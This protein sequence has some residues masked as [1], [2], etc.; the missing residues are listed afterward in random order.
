[1]VYNIL[2][3]LERAAARCPEKIALAD[4]QTSLTYGELRARAAQIGTALIRRC[5]GVRRPVFV[6]IDRNVESVLLFLGAVYSGNFYVPVD[7]A[8]PPAR[9]ESMYETVQPMAVLTAEET[10]LPFA[11]TSPILSL[12]EL[13]AEAEDL[14]ALDAVRAG[15]R[16]TDPLYCIFTSG[17]TGVPK[18]VVVGHRSVVDMAEGFTEVFGFGE[19]AVF[20]NQAPF[21]FDVSVKDIYIALKNAAT[22][23]ILE[24]KLFSFPKL[25]LERLGERR[26]NT[27]IWAASALKVV[28]ALRGLAKGGPEHLGTVCFS[29]EVLPCKALADWRAAL[30]E[31]RFI[32][33]YGPTEITCN[34]TYHVA[35]PG[36]GE[37]EPLPIGRAFPNCAVFLLDGD[38]PVTAPGEVGEI[39]VAGSCLAL[40]Y[41]NA[42]ELTARAFCQNPL[43][44]GYPERIYR[45]GDLGAYREDGLLRFAGRRDAQVK[46]M[47]HRVELGEIELCANAAA[48]VDCSAC[49]FDEEKD[50]LVLFYQGSAAE[51]EL[52]SALRDKLPKF[53]VPNQFVPVDG[54]PHTRTGKIDR[55]KLMSD[56]KSERKS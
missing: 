33:L 26:V 15:S 41:Y 55:K 49:V 21:D 31:A 47:G 13:L 42:P 5:G 40:G 32:N 28:S 51:G 30:P 56:L 38:R 7:L 37:A 35:S 20:G 2:T 4:A 53:M 1:M 14:A 25:L 34:C 6:A 19:T 27:V 46:H 29:G 50:K 39:C 45:T 18:G 48:G 54:F 3:Y 11:C 52:A 17:S 43:Q 36:E 22:V 16:D 10:A 24:K 8:L 44:S 23:E 9:L 12:D